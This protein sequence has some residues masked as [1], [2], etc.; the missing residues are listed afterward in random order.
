M[1]RVLL[2]PLAMLIKCCAPLVI[3]FFA[4]MSTARAEPAA[5]IQAGLASE[6]GAGLGMGLELGDGPRTLVVGAGLKTAVGYSSVE[7][8]IGAIVPG[9]GLGVRQ[10]LGNFYIGPTAGVGY[11]VWS[12]RDDRFEDE[13]WALSAMGDVGYRWGGKDPADSTFKLGLGLG[14]NWDGD[15]WEPDGS[16]TLAIGF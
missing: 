3:S 5:R 14:A 7:G 1:A 8:W 13:D 9:L 6:H 11:T 16:L 2:L 4:L 15:E 10:Y 12:T